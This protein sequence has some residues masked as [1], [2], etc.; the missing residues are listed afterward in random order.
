VYDAQSQAGWNMPEKPLATVVGANIAVKRRALG[1]TQ[2]ELAERLDLGKDALSRMEKGIIA[3]KMG[4]LREVA[5]ALRCSPAD[6]FREPDEE[7]AGRL[8]AVAESFQRL[9]SEQ[10]EALVRIVAEMVRVMGR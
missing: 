8:A 4:R 3:P 6:L 1:L 9:S 10:Q 2:A 7:S 5:S